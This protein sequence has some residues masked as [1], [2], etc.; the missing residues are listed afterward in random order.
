MI[1]VELG[2]GEF[3]GK[4][5]CF[6]KEASVIYRNEVLHVFPHFELVFNVLER[7][8]RYHD[9]S[10][11]RWRGGLCLSGFVIFN[12]DFLKA[13]CLATDPQEHAE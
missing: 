7:H 13:A 6:C 11:T 10:A 5:L 4:L 2:E 9:K 3:L 8:F 1:D 12:V